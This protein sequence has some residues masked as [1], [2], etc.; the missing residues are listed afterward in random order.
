MPYTLYALYILAAL[1]ILIVIVIVISS[2]RQLGGARRLFEGYG[3]ADEPHAGLNPAASQESC[4][5]GW[6]GIVGVRGDSPSAL[7]TKTKRD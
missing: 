2:A 7:V 6:A 5:R 1:V 4:P 3:A